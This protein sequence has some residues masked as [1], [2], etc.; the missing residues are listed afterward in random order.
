MSY[1]LDY[2]Y[3]KQNEDEFR[4]LYSRITSFNIKMTNMCYNVLYIFPI[5]INNTKEKVSNTHFQ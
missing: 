3:I 1:D 4:I 2:S 5:L